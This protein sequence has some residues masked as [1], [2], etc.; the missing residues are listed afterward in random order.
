MVEMVEALINILKKT[1]FFF[2]F[3]FVFIR[4]FR[5][6]LCNNKYEYYYND[7]RVKIKLSLTNI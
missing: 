2:K 6:F 7:N 4:V 3:I 1:H 5:Y